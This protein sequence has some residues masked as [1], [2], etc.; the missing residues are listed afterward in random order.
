MSDRKAFNHHRAGSGPALVLLHG[1]GHHWQAYAPVLPLL[2]D[3]DVIAVD[4]P[5]FGRSAP[6]P[7]GTP[8]TIAAYTDAFAAWFAQIG[9]ERPHVAGNSM[10]GGIALELARRGVVASAT[11]ISPVGFWSDGERRMCQLSLSALATMPA[12][13][14][15][16]VRSLA[17]TSAGRALLGGQLFARPWRVPGDEFVSVLDDAWNSPAF[18]DALASFDAYDFGAGDELAGVPVTVAWGSRDHLL[19]Y[20]RQAP[21]ARERLPR[22]RHVTLAG[23]GHVPTHDDPGVTAHAIRAGTTF[24]G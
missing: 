24:T 20:G 21:R 1:I 11:A 14:R 16:V 12:P 5:G 15:P 18:V 4:S 10:G 23:L 7:A 6:L 22:A 9:L 17:R 19:P 13:A 3:F 2:G 8:L